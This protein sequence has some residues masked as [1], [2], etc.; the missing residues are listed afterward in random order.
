[1]T[2]RPLTVWTE[3]MANTL[4]RPPSTKYGYALDYLYAVNSFEDDGEMGCNIVRRA[5]WA[6]GVYVYAREFTEDE[7]E[8]QHLENPLPHGVFLV[9]STDGEEC[10]YC[11]SKL[12]MDATN[13]LIATRV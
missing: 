11:A 2:R 1:M 8:A 7:L 5:T 10:E 6:E 4:V 13:W 3:L 12:A 9:F